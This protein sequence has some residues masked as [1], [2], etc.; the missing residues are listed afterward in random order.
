MDEP[1][2]RPDLNSV[3][4]A[5]LAAALAF[6]ALGW[7]AWY[8]FLRREPAVPAAPPA[9]SPVATAGPD[10]A[11][12]AQD[13]RLADA[14]GRYSGRPV[15]KEFLEELR[16]DPEVAAALAKGGDGGPRQLLEAAKKSAGARRLLLKYSLRPDFLKTLAEM[17]ADPELKAAASAPQPVP[18]AAPAAAG[19]R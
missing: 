10:R 9:A 13:R 6:G 8:V 12:G 19:S 1:L 3:L 5:L 4:A 14:A 2:R 17:K 15:M 16:R 7:A 11:A 18:G